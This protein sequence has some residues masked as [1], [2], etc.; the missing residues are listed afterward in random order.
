MKNIYKGFV[1]LTD[2][3]KSLILIIV[4][5]VL[6]FGFYQ[7]AKNKWADIEGVGDWFYNL[8]I[9]APYF[10]AY[11][12]ACIE[13]LGIVFLALGFF[14]RIISIPLIFAMIVAIFTVH[15]ENGFSAANNGIEIP[16]YYIVLLLILMTRGAGKISADYF[17]NK[18]M[19]KS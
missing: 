10:Q 18:K 9:P 16:L 12:I 11:L 6:A 3:L 14:V 8:G 15:L 19:L 1:L 13:T 5:F 2:R 17:I 7:P 4:R